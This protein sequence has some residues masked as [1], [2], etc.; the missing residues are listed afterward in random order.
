MDSPG[1]LLPPEP[2]NKQPFS[3]VGSD[4][5]SETFNSRFVVIIKV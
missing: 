4:L 5:N 3:A 2:T 1:G